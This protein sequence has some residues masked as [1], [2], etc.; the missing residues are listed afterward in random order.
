MSGRKKPIGSTAGM[1]TSL[2]T[3]ALL[4]HRVHSTVPQRLIAMTT[5]IKEHDFPKLA[6]L[7][8][9]VSATAAMSAAVC[10]QYQENNKI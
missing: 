7:T 8:M 6:M 5:A 3:S 10:L 2:D 1:Q 4:A 9:K